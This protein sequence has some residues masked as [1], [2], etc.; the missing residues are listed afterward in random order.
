MGRADP[1]QS[2]CTAKAAHGRGKGRRGGGGDVKGWRGK[3]GDRSV[4]FDPGVTAPLRVVAA[5]FATILFYSCPLLSFIAS[6][7]RITSTN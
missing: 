5:V 2:T 7:L 3:K 6:F 1:E 4:R